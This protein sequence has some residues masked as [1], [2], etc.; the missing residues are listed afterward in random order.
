MVV[1]YPSPPDRMRVCVCV[2]VYQLFTQKFNYKKEGT[3]SS[4]YPTLHLLCLS[5]CLFFL[6][7]PLS[8]CIFACLS[9]SVSMYLLN[10][11][12]DCLYVDLSPPV[13]LSVYVS[14]YV[15]FRLF[16]C[17]SLCLSVCRFD[18]LYL[19]RCMSLNMSVQCICIFS[20]SWIS[21]RLFRPKSS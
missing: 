1:W 19:L 9:V 21:L 11:M 5:S 4:V 2:C 13:C 6:P 8:V 7:V 18:C 20:E 10:R 12:F 3:S 15:S 14:I 16:A 17:L